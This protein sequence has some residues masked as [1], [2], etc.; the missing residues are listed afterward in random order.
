MTNQNQGNVNDTRKVKLEKIARLREVG[1]HPYPEKFERSCDLKTAR[2]LEMGAKVKVAGRIK[3]LRDM[4]KIA[5]VQLQDWSG[6]LQ[7][8][9]PTP[10]KP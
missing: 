2:E 6:K 7:S 4:G 3:L 1:I 8:D 5:F 10:N 9:Q